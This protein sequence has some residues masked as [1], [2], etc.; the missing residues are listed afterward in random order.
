MADRLAALVMRIRAG[1]FGEREMVCFSGL[2]LARGADGRIGIL[3]REPF[4]GGGDIGFFPVSAETWFTHD[5]RFERFRRSRLRRRFGDLVYWHLK[6][7]KPG[8]G[9]AN[10]DLDANP[11]SRYARRQA[12][13]PAD[14]RLVTTADLAG[15]MRPVDR[16]MCAARRNGVPLPEKI[17][18]RADRWMAAG[19]LAQV[20]NVDAVLRDLP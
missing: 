14:P 17:A 20:A 15:L 11:D 7:L 2:N 12:A 19:R 18:L 6:Y 4:S 9:F 10:Y 3:A 1:G 13:F 8:R 5:K 16:A